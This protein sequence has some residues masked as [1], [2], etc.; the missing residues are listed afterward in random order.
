MNLSLGARSLLLFV[1]SVLFLVF[2]TLFES[3]LTGVSTSMERLASF[4]LLVL[5]GMIGVALGIFGV[6]RKESNA[7]IAYLGILLNTLF[8]L[9]HLLVISFAG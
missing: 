7:W 2:L 4:L 3:L 1:L 9:F 8:A 6:I 5:P